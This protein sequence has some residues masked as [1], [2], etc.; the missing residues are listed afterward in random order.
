MNDGGPSPVE[1]PPPRNLD[2]SAAV[3]HTSHKTAFISDERGQTMAEYSLLVGA[4]ALVVILVLP[5][6]A[7][8]ISDIFSGA[9]G[10]L[11]G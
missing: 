8:A 6:F 1:G 10:A 5:D 11:G 4:L 7:T 3:T 9:V 2:T